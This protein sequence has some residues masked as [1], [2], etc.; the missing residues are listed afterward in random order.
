[1]GKLLF[2]ETGSKPVY[3]FTFMHQNL[4]LGIYFH[5]EAGIKLFAQRLRKRA[6]RE[7]S[8]KCCGE[9]GKKAA[10]EAAI[11]QAM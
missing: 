10:G 2:E 11:T 9:N 6:A 3:I 5:A 4:S 1:V 7:R 8:K